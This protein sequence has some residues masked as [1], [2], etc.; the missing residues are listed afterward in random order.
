MLNRT[1]PRANLKPTSTLGNYSKDEQEAM[2]RTVINL[3]AKWHVKDVDA[4]VI[5]GGVS[6][7][8]L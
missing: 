4:A 1:L 7:K 8:T 5:L 3:F 6:T 2:Q